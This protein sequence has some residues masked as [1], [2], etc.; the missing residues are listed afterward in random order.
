MVSTAFNSLALFR[1][2]QRELAAIRQATVAGAPNASSSP[3]DTGPLCRSHLVCDVRGLLGGLRA[4][5]LE[6]ANLNVVVHEY[7]AAGASGKRKRVV[8]LYAFIGAE[9]KESRLQ[10]R[11]LTGS[12][13]HW[14]AYDELSNETSA[15]PVG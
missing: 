10:R 3:A 7:G 15:A 9:E 2:Q 11:R 4:S 5:V 8:E 13:D 14:T 6:H 1:H 12:H